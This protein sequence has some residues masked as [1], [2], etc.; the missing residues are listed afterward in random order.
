MTINVSNGMLKPYYTI[1]HIIILHIIMY[2]IQRHWT[3][4][5][6]HLLLSANLGYTNGIIIII[7]IIK[8]SRPLLIYQP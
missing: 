5:T 2:I 6:A 7:I 3:L 1:L 8:E 4:T